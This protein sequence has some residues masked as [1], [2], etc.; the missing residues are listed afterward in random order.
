MAFYLALTFPLCL[1]SFGAV[2]EEWRQWTLLL[3]GL[4]GSAGLLLPSR[5]H[6]GRTTAATALISGL[7]LLWCAS[8]FLPLG[9]A[10]RAFLQPGLAPVLDTPLALA[11][12]EVHP[13]ALD[14]SRSLLEVLFL[15]AT[16]LLFLATA[17]WV[18][19]H[20][21]ARK[22]VLVV[23]V[24]GLSFAL[25]AFAQ[26]ATDAESIYWT[27][28]VPEILLRPFFGTLV[29]ANQGGAVCALLL[30]LALT[31][32]LLERRATRVF[33]AS[34][35]LLLAGGCV[36][37]QSRGACLAAL[38]GVGLVTLHHASSRH[39]RIFFLA[40]PLG[41]I[42]LAAFGVGRAALLYTQVVDPSAFNLIEGGYSDLL[43]GRADLYR[44]GWAIVK[45]APWFGVGAGG[46][47]EAYL[48]AKSTP[49]FSLAAHAHMEPL[50]IAAEHGLVALLLVLA[51]VF[52]LFRSGRSALRAHATDSGHWV[53]AFFAA[54]LSLCLVCLFDFPLRSGALSSLAALLA[55]GLLGLS[56]KSPA[57]ERTSRLIHKGALLTGFLVL[58]GFGLRYAATEDTSSRWS[59]ADASMG[60]GDDAW[61]RAHETS[62]STEEQQALLTE[63]ANH[64][65]RAIRKAPT[66]RDALQKMSWVVEKLQGAD[67]ARPWIEAAIDTYPTLSWPA[68][69]LAR[70]EQ[71][72]Q[73]IDAAAAAWKQALTSDLPDSALA[74]AWM[75]EFLSYAED[76]QALSSLL[77]P[78]ADRFVDAA[79]V[80]EKRGELEEAE[81]LLREAVELDPGS[82]V[83]LAASLL[84]RKRPQEALALVESSASCWGRRLKGEALLALERPTEAL[85]TLESTL[86]DC[87]TRDPWLRAQ[88][89]QARALTGDL[90]GLRVLEQVL[91]ELPRA[92]H[93]RRMLAGHLLDA[94]KW[95]EALVHLEILVDAGVANVNET[96]E[97]QALRRR[98]AAP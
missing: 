88:V 53:M 49:A 31:A 6:M 59:S 45:M 9:P 32:T 43:T 96:L 12:S 70:L 67:A 62:L 75:Q 76:S 40:L 63:A 97:Y 87:G 51:L 84:Q 8:A 24:T 10:G 73:N 4:L 66:R 14:P 86:E 2:H 44:D 16:L 46:F 13:L 90:S 1:F 58:A 79:W 17:T 81:G 52:L 30:P 65:T 64:Y 21:S 91:T 47:D 95:E 23:L 78:R 72:A 89:G 39:R 60:L 15:A 82:Q 22:L 19:N 55:G 77:P 56:D 33:A 68:R 74:R 57:S 42:A 50:Q 27:S 94:W 35:M 25:L 29:S 93:L 38:L 83:P 98:V 28:G 3:I 5:P 48:I 69:D 7:L 80:L 26:R 54:T 61:D 34:T 85:S 20:E 92:H 71:R 36:L 11:A 37:S 18:R 41:L